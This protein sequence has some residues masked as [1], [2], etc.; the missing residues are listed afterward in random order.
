MATVNPWI[1]RGIFVRGERFE[2]VGIDAAA[3]AGDAEVEVAVRERERGGI[4]LD[5]GG[6]GEDGG[7]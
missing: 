3:A 1:R 6:S 2:G 7:N 5:C 4:L